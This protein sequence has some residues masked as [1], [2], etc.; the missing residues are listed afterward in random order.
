MSVQITGAARSLARVIRSVETLEGGGFHV[1][2]PV[3]IR[4]VDQVDPFLLLDEMGPQ[5]EIAGRVV[6][7]PDHPHKGFEL[8]T[9]LL[10]GEMEHHDSHGNHG[11]LRAGDAQYMLGGTGLV[12]SEMP[13]DAFQRTGGRRHGFQIWVNLSRE[14][15]KLA[16]AYKDVPN[17]TI[18]VVHPAEGVTARVLAGNVFGVEGPV[19]TVVPWTYVHVTLEPGATIVQPVARELTATIYLFAGGAGAIGKREVRSGDYAVFNDDGETIALENTG[20]EPLE[21]LFLCARPT[22]EPMARYGPFVM[23]SVEEL[24]QAFTDFQAGRFGTIKPVVA[25]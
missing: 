8:I 6:G 4:G 18:P 9:Y 24:Q 7:A 11:I 3:P 21:A 14:D 19:H 16:P 25:K 5:D 22:R 17:A 13:T 23:N 10:A 20:K 15:K 12:H 1:R 2:R